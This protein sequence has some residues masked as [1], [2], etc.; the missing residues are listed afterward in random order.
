VEESVRRQGLGGRL[1][2]FALEL[3][4]RMAADYRA[5]YRCVG[6]VVVA[7]PAAI[8]F[9]AKHGFLAIEA[10]EGESDVRQKLTAMFL[11]MRAIADASAA[12]H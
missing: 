6:V 7:K 10:V 12:S 2:R 4:S 8:D 5:D 9:H 3:A 11:S 1:L